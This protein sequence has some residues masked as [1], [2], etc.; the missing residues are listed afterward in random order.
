[1]KY[2][3]V[4]LRNL[5]GNKAS[6]YSIV[7]NDET[8]S[9][10]EKFVKENQISFIDETKNILMR[11][12]SIGHKTGAR[13]TFFKSFEGYPGD[14]VCALY[15]EPESN[16]RLYCILYG[17]QLVVVG[18]GGP[19]PKEIRA[20]QEDDKLT[21]ENYFLRWLSG[22]ITNRIKDKEISYTNDYLDFTG[23]LEFQ[24]DERN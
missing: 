9:F 16:L 22:E 1:M 12:K 14:G 4:K 11:L 3:L 19:K 21:D 13:G 23:N 15:D 2:K 18:N 20:F 17:T 10:L 5:S 7:Q 6:I 24:D 8:E